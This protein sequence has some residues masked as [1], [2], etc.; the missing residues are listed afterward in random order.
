MKESIQK[1]LNGSNAGILSEQDH[2]SWFRELF[3]PSVAAG[4]LQPKDLAGYRNHQVYIGN[5]KHVPINV[6]AMRDAMPVL[7][8]LLTEESEASVRAVLGHFIFVYIHPYMDGNGRIGRFLMNVMLA[9]GGY[10]WTIIPVESRTTYMQA[11]ERA[12]VDQDITPFTE[13]LAFLVK[14]NMDGRRS[15]ELPKE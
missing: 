5:S 7:F 8:E 6:E 11:L 2:E 1:I 9:S 12:S 13:F 15:A 10:P 3:N 14:E 4:L